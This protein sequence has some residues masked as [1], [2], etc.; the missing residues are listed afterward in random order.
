MYAYIC[1]IFTYAYKNG[2]TGMISGASKVLTVLVE[3]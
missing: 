2:M 3:Q 1:H